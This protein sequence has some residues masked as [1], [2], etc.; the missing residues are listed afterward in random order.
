MKNTIY[1]DTELSSVSLENNNIVV[2]TEGNKYKFIVDAIQEIIIRDP[3]YI[4]SKVMEKCVDSGIE[5]SV[6]DHR[7]NFKYRVV[8][9][10][11]GN[12]EL[13]V[14]QYKAVI[15]NNSFKIAQAIVKGKINNQIA[16][17]E[18]HKRNHGSTETVDIKLDMIKTM[19]SRVDDAKTIEVLMGLEGVASKEYFA[20]FN[21]MMH[22]SLFVFKGRVKRPPIGEVNAMLSYTYT[23]LAS[24]AQSALAIVGL[25][26]YIGFLHSI[27]SGKPALALDLMEE[28]RPVLADRLVLSIINKGQ[29]KQEWFTQTDTGT[30]MS[31]ECRGLLLREWESRGRREIEHTVFN[32]Q[33][34]YSE[35]L[36]RQA[37]ILVDTINGRIPEYIPY[38]WG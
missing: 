32:E 38:K 22:N 28:M 18:R 1:V 20:C 16:L 23:L 13:R 26:A 34:K 14:N 25:D 10:I 19:R 9:E 21:Y 37:K 3:S 30:I 17:I 35:L 36:T 27:K 11:K 31:K 2:S 4:T 15:S 5:M 12:V 29:V 33:I 8:G 6:L 7:G 24:K